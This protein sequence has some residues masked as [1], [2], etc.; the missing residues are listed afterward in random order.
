VDRAC[1]EGRCETD[2]LACDDR[3]EDPCPAGYVCED[4]EC[5]PGE[6]DLACS[7][8][9]PD[10][11][12]AGQFCNPFTQKCE[13]LGGGEC[14]LCNSDCTCGGGLTCEEGLCAG[15]SVPFDPACESNMC[16]AVSERTLC[17]P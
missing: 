2:R 15:C 13:D 12:S 16:S 6:Q 7:A 10:V 8:G 9:S 1:V 14:G 5:V 4:S 11:C 3:E 17:Q